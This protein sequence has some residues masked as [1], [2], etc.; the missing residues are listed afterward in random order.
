MQVGGPLLPQLLSGLER[1]R[2]FHMLPAED[3]EGS[4]M[5]RTSRPAMDPNRLQVHSLSRGWMADLAGTLGTW[6]AVMGWGRAKSAQRSTALGLDHAE[7]I[8]ST[9]H[10]PWT[11]SSDARKVLK[12][13]MGV[14]WGVAV[15]ASEDPHR[16]PYVNVCHDLR[17]REIGMGSK[18]GTLTIY[19]KVLN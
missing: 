7:R 2:S 1:F 16:A 18:T 10:K 12:D 8:D 15:E 13:G 14:S 6:R 3:M 9:F 4:W 11:S 17:E 5:L 19:P